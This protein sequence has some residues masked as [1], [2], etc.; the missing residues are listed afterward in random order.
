LRHG[1][2]LVEIGERLGCP[3][4]ATGLLHRGVRNRRQQLHDLE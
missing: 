4:A 2:S 1:R 3:T